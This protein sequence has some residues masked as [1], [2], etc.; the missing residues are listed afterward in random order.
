VFGGYD[1]SARLGDL[2]EFQF[3]PGKLCVWVAVL[4]VY[5][6]LGKK[7]TNIDPGVLNTRVH[8]PFILTGLIACQLPESTLVDDLRSFVN[9]AR[10]RRT[11]ENNRL[12]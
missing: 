9:Q 1:G 5:G 8:I 2:L 11:R 4:G 7:N 12:L 3:G 6:R 10:S